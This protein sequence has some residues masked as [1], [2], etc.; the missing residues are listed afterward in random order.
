LGNLAFDQSG[1]IY[2]TTTAGGAYNTGTVFE[3]VSSGTN[4]MVNILYSFL[5]FGDSGYAPGCGT[6]FQLTG[7]S[8]GTWTETFIHEFDGVDGQGP[9]ALI[10]DRS[11]KLY[12]ATGGGGA[13]NGGTVFELTFSVPLST[14][15]PQIMERFMKYNRR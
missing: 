12:G 7:S 1:N 15:A 10:A 5:Y 3:L 8:G 14:A 11:G 6:V 13:D 9:G 4:W 2:G